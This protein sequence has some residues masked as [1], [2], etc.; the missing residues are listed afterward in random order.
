MKYK[1]K[2]DSILKM[3]RASVN[4]RT[5]LR[6]PKDIQL[7]FPKERTKTRKQKMYYLEK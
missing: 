2:R 3:N 6:E 4:R 1:E 7:E 5:T